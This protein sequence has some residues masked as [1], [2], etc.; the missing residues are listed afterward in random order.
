MNLNKGCIEIYFVIISNYYF[1]WMN[2]NKG[3]IE[4]LTLVCLFS[5]AAGWTLTRVV[6]KSAHNEEM[7]AEYLTM[8]LNKGCIEIFLWQGWVKVLS[9]WTLTRVVLKFCNSLW[10]LVPLKRWTLTRV[11]LKSSWW[12]F[13][14]GI[15]FAM[16]LNKGCIEIKLHLYLSKLLSWMNLNKGCIEIV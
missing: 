11:V 13:A 6:L 15:P 8:N 14:C 2:L 7:T 5:P 10:H 3:C 9:R 4:M 16:N 1:N 12:V